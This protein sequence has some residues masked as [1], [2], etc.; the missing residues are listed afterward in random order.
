MTVHIR[1]FSYSFFGE[2]VRGGE[3]QRNSLDFNSGFSK[4]AH[5][6]GTPSHL[7]SNSGSTH[8]TI[9]R[10]Y[11]ENIEDRSRIGVFRWQWHVE[12]A[13]QV[14]LERIRDSMQKPMEGLLRI[15]RSLF[16]V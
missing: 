4:S 15:P 10:V 3:N 14:Y 1:L 6:I 2:I 11:A 7:E 12:K 9:Q 8:K 5:C 16:T 13:V